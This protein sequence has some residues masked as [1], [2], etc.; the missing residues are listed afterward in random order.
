M[1][2]KAIDKLLNLNSSRGVKYKY[3][4]ES[5]CIILARRL[6]V[7]V[8]LLRQ[9]EGPVSQIKKCKNCWEND[10]RQYVNLLCSRGELIEP[11]LK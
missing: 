9:I 2:I 1:S 3:I 5:P 7:R 4:F 6:N 11:G 10:P 8:G